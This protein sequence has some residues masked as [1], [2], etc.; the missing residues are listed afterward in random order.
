MLQKIG[1]TLKNHSWL[2]YL[3]FGA[4]ILIFAA[5]GAYG[6]ASLNFGGSTSA[7]KVNGQAI[8][9]EEVRQ[10]WQQQQAQWQQRYGTDMPDLIKA[11]MQDQLLESFVR[12][13]L[14][15]QRTHDL[16]YAVTDQQVL[17]ALEQEP[18]FQLDGK[19]SP[20]VAKARLQQAGITPEAFEAD[21]R[22]ALQRAQLGN[23]IRESEF[24]T[25]AELK[26]IA[27]LEN[28]QREV[29]YATLPVDKFAGTAPIDE[30][31]VKAYYDAHKAQFMTEE[32]V[33]LQYAELKLDQLQSQ[34]QLSDADLH[35]YYDKNKSHYVLP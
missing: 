30:A 28:E 23:S 6:V 27:A 26:R 21:M 22:T 15:T 1:D 19:Y 34:V 32:T 2:T 25:P 5:W 13:S 12:T 11:R 9:I 4:L 33:R 20:E 8:S 7:A 3:L 29:R 35:E 10:S 17:E 16:G 31:A 18:A 14:M 24:L